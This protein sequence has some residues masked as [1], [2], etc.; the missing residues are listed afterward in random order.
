MSSTDLVEL[1]HRKNLA[2]WQQLVY[3]CRNSGMTVRAWCAQHGITEKAYYY[4]QRKVWEAVRQLEIVQEAPRQAALPAIIPCS[5]PLPLAHED[6]ARTPALVLRNQNWTVEV[7]AEC[8]P[9][10][11]RLVLRTVK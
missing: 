2:R 4:R 8:D 5:R 9:E 3:E 6:S 1:N 11:L 7:A 10:L